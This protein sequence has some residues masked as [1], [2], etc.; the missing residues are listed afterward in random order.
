MRKSLIYWGGLADSSAVCK[1]GPTALAARRFIV[2][3]YLTIDEIFAEELRRPERAAHEEA[4][5]RRFIQ[6][7]ISKGTETIV[8][9][10]QK[11]DVNVLDDD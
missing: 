1:R 7:D 8:T 5:K 6:V 4:L 11:F 2:T 3:S 10:L 9:N